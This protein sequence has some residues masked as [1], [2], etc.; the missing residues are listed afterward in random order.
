M[1]QDGFEPSAK[2][3]MAIH[4]ARTDAAFRR[5]LLADAPAALKECGVQLPEGMTVKAL[6]NTPKLYHLVL[7][8]IVSARRIDEQSEGRYWDPLSGTWIETKG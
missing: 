1:P 8:D 6:E 5:R 3:Q 2:L 7:P 4:K